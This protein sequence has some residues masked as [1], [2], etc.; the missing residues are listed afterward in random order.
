MKNKTK[1]IALIAMVVTAITITT[2]RVKAQTTPANAW[3]I[4]IGVEVADPTG[5]ARIGSHFILGGTARIQYGVSNGLALT[6]TSGAYHF[7][8][9][10]NPAT[11]SDY[12]SYGV[13]PIKAGI[14]AFFAPNLYFGACRAREMIVMYTKV[15]MLISVA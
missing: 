5:N 11:G 9:T 8:P 6:F 1:F 2:Q 7:F 3:R 12:N 15:P 10:T 13:I 4:G 14:K